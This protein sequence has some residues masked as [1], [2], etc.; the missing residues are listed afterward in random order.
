MV[1]NAT[2]TNISV[3]TKR[4]NDVMLEVILELWIPVIKQ[5][6]INK[7]M[8]IQHNIPIQIW[9]RRDMWPYWI[10]NQCLSPLASIVCDIVLKRKYKLSS[11]NQSILP[12]LYS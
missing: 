6:Y 5:V 7:D 3:L 10:Y 4:K 9:G 12:Y 1:H 2:F 11:S 8:H